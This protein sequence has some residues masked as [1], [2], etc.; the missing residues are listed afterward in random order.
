MT[1][2]KHA[3]LYKERCKG[4]KTILIFP[5]KSSNQ[6]TRKT[7]VLKVLITVSLLFILVAESQCSNPC[8]LGE[9]HNGSSTLALEVTQKR[10]FRVSG[11]FLIW[12]RSIVSAVYI[13]LLQ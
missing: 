12:D 5:P 7:M 3:H 4:E 10:T 6:S 13:M 8:S 9:V 11:K 1:S 2:L